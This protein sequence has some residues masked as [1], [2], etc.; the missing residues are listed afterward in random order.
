MN[1]KILKLAIEV[2]NEYGQNDWVEVSKRLARIYGVVLSADA[3]RKRVKRLGVEV[4]ETYA[5][6]VKIE[7]K[8]DGTQISERIILMSETDMKDDEF[9]LKAHGFD[10]EIFTIVNV[11]STMWK[12]QTKDKDLHN[13]HSKLTV[14]MKRPDELDRGDILAIVKDIKPLPQIKL[15]PQASG[16]KYALEID[17]ADIH[18]GSLSWHE[19]TGY[20][21]DYKITFGGLD[22]IIS[23]ARHIIETQPIEKL[24]LCFLGDFLHIDT[25][26]MTTTKGTKVDFDSRPK[27]MLMKGYEMIMRI[28]DTLAI[29]ETEVIWIEGNHSRNLE[30]AV[31]YGIPFAYKT[32]KHIKF[33]VSPKLRKAFTYGDVL[34]GLHHGE[35]NKN[36]KFNWLQVEFR[37]EWGKAKF[38]ET[39]S[40]H[41]HHE[42]TTSKGGIVERSN[43]T[44]KIIDKYEYE[45]GYVGTERA[46]MAYL[47][48]K[49]KGLLQINYLKS[50]I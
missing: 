37:E 8:A 50:F 39:H 33:D 45:E 14:K 18:I 21:N 44:P 25:E 19:E 41:I 12:V 46:V 34:V 3:C 30:F 48:H 42:S 7:R 2:K 15:K 17:L 6:Q 1:D 47:W 24:Y 20:D 26:A 49:N 28:I 43:P 5:D 35:M 29:V 27:K 36:H 9:I 16:E 40:G 23:Q 10:P 4:E 22:E 38:T 32:N 31:F 13:Y 11:Q